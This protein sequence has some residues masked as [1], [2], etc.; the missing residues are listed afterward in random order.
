MHSKI[1]LV[2]AVAA[3]VMASCNVAAV[4]VAYKSGARVV[5]E[6]ETL[7][8]EF[9]QKFQKAAAGVLQPEA[10]PAKTAP[11]QPPPHPAGSSSSSSTAAMPAASSSSFAS[12][13][14]L[15]YRV[16]QTIKGSYSAL[17]P[18]QCE[19]TCTVKQAKPTCD[20]HVPPCALGC[21]EQCAQGTN[22]V[23]LHRQLCIDGCTLFCG[24][25]APMKSNSAP[26]QAA[27]EGQGDITGANADREKYARNQ[28]GK[29]EAGLA[30]AEKNAALP[31][32][33][34][35]QRL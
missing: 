6:E 11:P 24:A 16:V 13:F 1:V 27:L 7:P 8:T 15:S 31:G 30:Q 35:Q 9:L 28:V 22:E 26:T 20:W 2:A 29:G 21:A 10:A 34:T 18:L 19:S 17:G 5:S 23:P 33:T 14:D 12:A 32:A 3:A 4:P 25:K